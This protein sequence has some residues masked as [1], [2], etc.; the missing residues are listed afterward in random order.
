MTFCWNAASKDKC[1]F[2]DFV[3]E[4]Y[5]QFDFKWCPLAPGPSGPSELSSAEIGAIVVGAYLGVT[6]IAGAAAARTAPVP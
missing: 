1:F 4:N 3:A 2:D 6:A 5:D